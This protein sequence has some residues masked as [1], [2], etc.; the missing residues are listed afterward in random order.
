M[1]ALARVVKNALAM[2]GKRWITLGLFGLAL[3]LGAG[4]VSSTDEDAAS[5]EGE[6]TAG[7]V[8]AMVTEKLNALHGRDKDK[9]WFRTSGSLEGDW[10]MQTPNASTWG[11]RDIPAPPKCGSRP[12]DPTLGLVQCARDADCGGGVRCVRLAASKKSDADAPAGLCAGHSDA[13]ILDPIYDVISRASSS[14]D[15][16]TLS[17]PTGR[18]L[19]TIQN[20]LQTLD[21]R[22]RPVVV[23]F[24]VGSFPGQEANLDK[25]LSDL[26]KDIPRSTALRVSVGKYK[27]SPVSWNHSKIIAADGREAIIGGMNLWEDHY[28]DAEPV[29]DVSLRVKGA[30]AASAQ[31]FVNEL[32]AIPC[33]AVSNDIRGLS[34][35]GCPTA[36]SGGGSGDA[37]GNVPML[38]VG[39]LGKA[40]HNPSD[41]ALVTMMD[42]AVRSIKIAQQDIG[43]VK[44]LL[45]G[46]LPDDYLD[47]FTRAARRNVDV[48]ILVSNEHSYGGHG[49]T[50]A[51]S[52]SNGWSTKDLWDGL[53]RRANEL[54]PDTEDGLT[55]EQRLCRHVKFATI[56]SSDAST[57][58][59]GAPLANHSKVVI[60][61]DGAYYVGSQNLYEANLGEFGVIVDDRNATRTFLDQYYSPLLNYSIRTAYA[62]PACR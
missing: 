40:F 50:Q 46:T 19:G 54:W 43:S 7:R 2:L 21:K 24:L 5:V 39:R 27:R 9:V 12:C 57:W 14:V 32:W 62:P 52:Y 20:A 13:Q 8:T 51:D 3:S 36:F 11:V 55:I 47:A 22:R 60:V 61:D 48:T 17:A 4:C 23:R 15:V 41:T 37:G 26:T 35:D 18:F 44:V 34:G 1:P 31:R 25:I 29:H 33:A 59:S 30:V 6:L 49:R 56:R 45:G 16:T 42:A 28:L 38:A 58:A 53:V 10:L